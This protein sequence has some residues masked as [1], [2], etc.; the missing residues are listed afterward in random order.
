MV[1][2]IWLYMTVVVVV[3]F[4]IIVPGIFISLLQ[5]TV[6]I[7][8][9]RASSITKVVNIILLGGENISFDTNIVMGRA[10]A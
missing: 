7:M 2:I 3:S 5:V 4:S 6:C 9:D 8:Y 10:V 1:P